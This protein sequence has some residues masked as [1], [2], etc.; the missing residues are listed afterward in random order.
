M[1]STGPLIKSLVAAAV[2]GPLLVAGSAHANFF[3]AIGRIFGG[4][5]S[6]PPVQ[7]YQPAPVETY[8]EAPR[9]PLGVTVRPRQTQRPTFREQERFVRERPGFPRE[10]VVREGVREKP[11]REKRVAEA[12]APAEPVNLDPAK[13]ASW[14]LQDP[15][16]R[17]GDIVVLK[18]EVLVFEGG[19]GGPRGR[20]DFASLEQSRLSPTEKQQLR[21][22]A[23]VQPLQ[24]TAQAQKSQVATVVA[25]AQN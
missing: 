17:P 8:E 19:R 21:E 12:V 4:E 1:R 3:D 13:N 18:G 7:Q 15:T 6:A 14:Y 10:R 9:R 25:A 16:L 11:V 5:S 2:V 20:E 22:M 23:G 24:K